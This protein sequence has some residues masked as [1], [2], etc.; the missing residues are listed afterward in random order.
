[1]RIGAVLLVIWLIIGVVA[2]G[3]PLLRQ[4]R[5]KLREGEH[6]RRDRSR[7]PA[8]LCRREPEGLVHGLRLST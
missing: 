3:P 7:G 8:Q 6:D 2:A 4:L 1:M 5:P